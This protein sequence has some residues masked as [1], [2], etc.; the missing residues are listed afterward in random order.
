MNLSGL[1]FIFGDDL[2]SMTA[3]EA[4]IFG[5]AKTVWGSPLADGATRATRLIILKSEVHFPV[6]PEY[7][8]T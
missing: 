1:G 5:V 3:D 6:R 2:P 8:L 7:D 4:V